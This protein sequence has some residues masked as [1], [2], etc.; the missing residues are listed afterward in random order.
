VTN[1]SPP[2]R[3]AG[4]GRGV[5][6]ATAPDGRLAGNRVL[7]PPALA[8]FVH[9]FWSVRWDLRSPFTAEALPHPSARIVLDESGGA[10]SAELAGVYTGR[11][12]RRLEG[13][14][15]TFGVTFRAAMAQPLLGAPMVCVTDR[16]VPLARVLGPGVEPWTRAVL[17][18]R[19]LETKVALASDF[20]ATRVGLARPRIV[21]LRDLVERMGRDRSLLRL[22]QVCAASGLGARALQRAFSRYVGL[23]PKS[24]LQRYRL[25]EASEQLRGPRPP[26]LAALATSLGYADQAHFAR[27]FKLTVGRSPGAFARGYA[28]KASR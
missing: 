16:V 8:P 20:L 28:P 10:H 21:R 11:F 27:D 7:P 25:L 15:Q 6:R 17:A 26:S 19:D 18:A 12:A 4:P 14:G 3:S 22:D 24:V 9:H 13:R 1:T 23:S 5:L 2:L